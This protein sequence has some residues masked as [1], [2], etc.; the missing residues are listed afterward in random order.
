MSL[1]SEQPGRFD[2]PPVSTA[3]EDSPSRLF[4][5]AQERRILL[6]ALFQLPPEFRKVLTLLYWDGCSVE[7]IA[8]ELDIP[9]GT[10]KSRLARG[11]AALKE[12]LLTMKL[13]SRP[14]AKLE[15]LLDQRQR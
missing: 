3:P 5:F 4:A 11:R 14:L 8:E 12:Q 2:P 6:R 1:R 15:E 7:D 10:V 9:V 13:P